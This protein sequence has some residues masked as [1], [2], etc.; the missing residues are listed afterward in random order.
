M[1]HKRL[2]AFKNIKIE[3]LVIPLF[4]AIKLLKNYFPF[5]LIGVFKASDSNW[6]ADRLVL[7]TISFLA[8]FFFGFT[9]LAIR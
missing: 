4:Y 7:T 1:A 6:S 8:A 9:A 5:F 3:V 2:R